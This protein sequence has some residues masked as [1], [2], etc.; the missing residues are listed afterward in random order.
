MEDGGRRGRLGRAH[1]V[2]PLPSAR[3]T[4]KVAHLALNPWME[5]CWYFREARSQFRLSGRASVAGAEA[6]GADADARA[7]AWAKLSPAS[8]EW[9]AGPPPGRLMAEGE[10]REA[11]S[12][13]AAETRGGSGGATAS[14]SSTPPHPHFC[15]VLLDVDAVS[16]SF[17]ADELVRSH[18]HAFENSAVHIY[19]FLNV[20]YLIY[21]FLE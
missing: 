13:P 6:G 8:R 1:L 10:K 18:R 4:T 7:A 16:T 2:L 5:A 12:A 21:R 19:A 17:D 20:V 3:S 9:N 11:L 15:L 14:P